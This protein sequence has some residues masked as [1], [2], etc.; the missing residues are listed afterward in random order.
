MNSSTFVFGRVDSLKRQKSKIKYDN[1]KKTDKKNAMAN[2]EDADETVHYLFW[3][4]SL[5]DRFF[6]SVVV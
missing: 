1:T 3:I 5:Q 2:S 6:L 4:H